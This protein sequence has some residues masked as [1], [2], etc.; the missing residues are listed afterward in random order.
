M[1]R[2]FMRW[3]GGPW[4]YAVKRLHRGDKGTVFGTYLAAACGA[5]SNTPWGPR[6]REYEGH[7]GREVCQ[8]C[9]RLRVVAADEEVEG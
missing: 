4:H 8:R 7:P 1:K 6:V 9:A 2:R 3:H 5:R